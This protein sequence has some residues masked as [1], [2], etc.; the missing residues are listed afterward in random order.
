MSRRINASRQG[1]WNEETHIAVVTDVRPKSAK[2][3]RPLFQPPTLKSSPLFRQIMYAP[4][5]EEDR[6][7]WGNTIGS[8][9]MEL[10]GCI[11]LGLFVNIAKS[12]ASGIAA[13]A[14]LDGAIIGAVYGAYFYMAW[15]WTRDYMLRRHM[16]WAISWGYLLTLRIG[17]L[18]WILFYGVAQTGGAFIAGAILTATPYGTPPDISS[19][20]LVPTVGAA[21]GWE[22][23]GSFL[24]VF[25]LIYNEILENAV[26]SAAAD[27]SDGQP[28]EASRRAAEDKYED[29]DENHTRAGKLTGLVIFIL[30]TC[31][32]RIQVYSFN[33]V[34]YLAGLTGTGDLN[35]NNSLGFAMAYCAYLGMPLVG[36]TAAAFIFWI[37]YMLYRAI[38]DRRRTPSF[39]R[40]YGYVKSEVQGQ[41]QYQGKSA[42][43][44]VGVRAAPRKSKTTID[45]T[46]TRNNADALKGPFD[47]S[48]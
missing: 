32:F 14:L 18:T 12:N 8:W 5:D 23:F 47:K 27:G 36:A 17:I 34:V 35:A 19:A 39:S 42:N 15:D 1:G 38:P 44:N 4:F 28:E 48:L 37:L 31:F 9:V 6:P 22:F 41:A 40:F 7:D 10:V 45:H 21:L 2:G 13:N 25:T 24:I 43:T 46:S 20:A 3:D 11:F 16:N 26:L 29:E 30:V 33:N